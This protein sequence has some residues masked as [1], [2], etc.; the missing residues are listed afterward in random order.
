M[1]IDDEAPARPLPRFVPTLTEVVVSTPAHAPAPAAEG[2]PPAMP[3]VPHLPPAA[4]PVPHAPPSASAAPRAEPP[5]LV[6]ALLARLGPELERQIAEAVGRVLH[7][8]ML[9]F[10]GRVRKAVADVVHDAMASALLHHGAG[11][12]VGENPVK[13]P[14]DT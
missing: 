9:G 14:S 11:T 4:L 10:N 3:P 8:Q 13:W 7:E 1:A 6:E 12:D 5:D 2:P